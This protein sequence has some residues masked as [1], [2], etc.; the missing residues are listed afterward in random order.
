[1]ADSATP[2]PIALFVFNRPDH[3]RK[4]LEALAA[5]YGASDSE[6]TIFCDAARKPE[7]IKLT[8]E[9]QA[10]ARNAT[11][12]KS[13]HVVAHQKNMGCA[14]SIIAGV[15]EVL[16]RHDRII[17][18]EDDILTAPATLR[19]LNAGL[20][21]YQDYKT[22]FNVT[23][24]APPMEESDIPND[25]PYDILFVPRFNCWG[26]A[27][28]KDRWRQIDWNMSDYETFRNSPALQKA[29]AH[30]GTKELVNLVHRQMRGE[31]NS[32][33]VRADYSRFKHRL[34]SACPFFSFT[35]NIGFD[36][37]GTHCHTVNPATAQKQSVEKKEF[38]FPNHILYDER[39]VYTFKYE[40]AHQLKKRNKLNKWFH[41][42][43]PR[44]Y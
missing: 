40:Q 6:L 21:K 3:T 33:A 20:E 1:M 25:Y 35:R 27:I 23:A 5:N 44:E 30:F 18:I 31:I 4:T 29:Y 16:E 12:F 9:V 41:K 22:V 15:T 13:V 28:W 8:E 19:F 26:W 37:S 24:W 38:H 11:G 2:A 10:I 32:W 14:A 39:L 17:V 42:I 34:V 36:G 7:E 43:F